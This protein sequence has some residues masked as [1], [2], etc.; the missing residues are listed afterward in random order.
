LISQSSPNGGPTDG[1]VPSWWIY[2]GTGQPREGLD[3]ASDLPVAPPW[4]R[5]TGAPALAAPAADVSDAQRRLGVL[6]APAVPPDPH[7]V[8]MT[9]A[10]LLLRRPLLITG[11]PGTGKSS[12]AFRVARE[13]GLGRVLQW[14]VTSR[15]TLQAGLYGYDAIG[16]AQATAARDPDTRIGNFIHLGPLGTAM[17]PYEFPRVL[18]VDE[19]DKSD[20]DLPNDL[21]HVFEDGEFEIPELVR[22]RDREREVTVFTNDPD[23]TVTIVDGHV[24][25]KAFPFVVITSNGER[26]FPAAFLR[27][28]LRL[29]MPPLRQDQL[30]AIVAAH[31]GPAD[32]H[33]DLIRQFFER[34]RD[35][36]LAADQLLNAVYLLSSNGF[37]TD[38]S[39]PRL[40]DALWRELGTGA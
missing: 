12:L 21:L 14:R 26:E 35:R 30:A 15:S 11:A 34:G 18:L 10:A 19:L 40:L 27:R 1:V 6:S 7:E 37:T 20:I 25:C 2:T 17:L 23:R 16:R 32:G 39:W 38:T 4:R 28:C 36:N 31:L 24:R 5:F 33:E 13:L 9:N 3:L 22:L 8:D 29:E